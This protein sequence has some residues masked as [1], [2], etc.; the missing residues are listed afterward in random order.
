MH[1][2][3]DCTRVWDEKYLKMGMIWY[4]YE[5]TITFWEEK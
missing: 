3:P 2:L 1:G 5:I 4:L